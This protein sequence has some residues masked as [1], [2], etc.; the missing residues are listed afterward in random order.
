MPAM[1]SSSA[2]STSILTSVGGGPSTSSSLTVLT[3]TCCSDW[4]WSPTL[5]RRVH[6]RSRTTTRSAVPRSLEAA[7][8]TTSTCSEVVE[9]R[10]RADR[11]GALGVG[12]DRD[13]AARRADDPRRDERE[14]A[15]VRADVPDVVAGAGGAHDRLLDLDLVRAGEDRVGLRAP[16]LEGARVD[17][18]PD[19]EAAEDRELAAAGEQRERL[20]QAAGGPA[21]HPLVRHEAHEQ[22]DDAG[23]REPGGAL[24]RLARSGAKM[25]DTRRGPAAFPHVVSVV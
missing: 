9:L 5:A 8:S 12:L 10:V 20:E 15:D 25:A 7:A 22:P 2:P 3:R 11:G 21:R 19:G 23:A 14:V 16:R 6:R 17:A 1:T 13:D 24:V 18:Q 4:W